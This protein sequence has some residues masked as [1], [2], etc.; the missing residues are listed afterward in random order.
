MA[1]SLKHLGEH[2]P[3]TVP[4]CPDRRFGIVVSEYHEEITSALLK[5]ATD[6][7]LAHEVS[8]DN[9]FVCYVPGAFE[10]PL[11]SLK[12]FEEHKLDAVIALGCVVKGETDHDIYI[13]H[14]VAKG[15]MNLSIE[16]AKPFIFGLL[17]PN[18]YE[19]ALDR[20]GGKHGNKGIECAIAALKMVAY[21]EKQ[22][23]KIGF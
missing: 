1:S 21:Y 3:E 12:I 13:N 7:L 4:N 2:S 22:K 20:A 10:M 8:E 18:N 19:Q 6:T 14:A 23:H 17:T 9:I 11:G 16:H 15:M 5:G